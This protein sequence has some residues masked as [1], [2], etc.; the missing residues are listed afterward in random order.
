MSDERR[1]DCRDRSFARVLLRFRGRI[2]YV[3]DVSGGGFRG[4]FPEDFELEAG[5]P[6]ELELGF[7]ELGIDIF[8]LSAL[9]KWIRRDEGALEAGFELASAEPRSLELFNRI[10]TY[11]SNPLP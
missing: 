5:G 6:I 4:L 11:Y 2:G 9:V 8:S 1:G 3:A 10:R 7:E